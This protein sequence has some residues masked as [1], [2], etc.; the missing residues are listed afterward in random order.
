MHKN[1]LCK[2]CCV[3]LVFACAC[4]VVGL[5]A[6]HTGRPA[7]AAQSSSAVVTAGDVSATDRE[8][9]RTLEKLLLLQQQ[10]EMLETTLRSLTENPALFGEETDTVALQTLYTEQLSATEAQIHQTL[11]AISL[12][13]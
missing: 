12:P 6:L 8:A 1:K 3:L 10:K 2:L 7:T 9:Y 4:G 11:S 5:F 13:E